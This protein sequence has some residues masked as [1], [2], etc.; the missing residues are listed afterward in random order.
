MPKILP[1][2]AALSA[3]APMLA[4]ADIAPP[5]D[6]YAGPSSVHVAGLTFERRSF[7]R[8]VP[9]MAMGK[10]HDPFDWGGHWLFLTSCDDK[11]PNCVLAKAKGALG[12]AVTQ[13]DG[14]DKDA[15]ADATLFQNVFEA[16]K[17][18]KKGSVA[19]TLLFVDDKKRPNVPRTITVEFK[20]R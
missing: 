14:K 7:E 5:P 15:E 16:A 13:V 12:G 10:D 4:W 2:I 8:R 6:T 19:L 17:T 9:L 3:F 20:A 11:A 18:S 1:W